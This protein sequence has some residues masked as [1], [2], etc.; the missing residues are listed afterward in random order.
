M[1]DQGVTIDQDMV[2]QIRRDSRTLVRELGFMGRTLAGTALSPSAVHALIEIGAA[3]EITAQQLA[4]CLLLEKSTISRL[5]ASLVAKGLIEERQSMADR[6][7]KLIGLTRAGQNQL[8]R[9]HRHG[10]EVVACSVG[11]CDRAA[12]TMVAAGLTAY[13]NALTSARLGSEALATKQPVQP[14]I[15]SGYHPGLLGRIVELHADYYREKAGF[16]LVFETRVAGDMAEFLRR[17][18]NPRNATW[19][20]DFNGRVEGGVSIDG[21]DLGGNC[22]HLRWFI[23][24]PALHGF[25]LGRAL[26]DRAMAFVREQHFD[27]A[28]LWTFQGL[29]AARAIYEKQGF[30][31]ES[32]NV[33]SSW[34]AEVR[35][36][37]FVFDC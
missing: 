31:L 28:R 5:V 30:R 17:I 13:S 22:A 20:V 11:R 18:D 3:R 1:S 14:V 29:D 34:G 27:Q 10:R 7:K 15:R 32:E 25:G 33:A 36:Q 37:A 2:Q 35:E 24:N 26:M 4:D 19:Y 8:A 21:E 23:V 12:A 16:G 6:R 9:I